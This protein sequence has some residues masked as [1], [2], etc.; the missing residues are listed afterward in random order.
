MDRQLTPSNAA[1]GI[2]GLDE[3]LAGGL[4]RGALFLVEGTPGTGKTTLALRFLIEGAAAGERTLYI[5]LS[6][7]RNELLQGAASH[8][9]TL[10]PNIEI[11]E[12]PPPESVVNADQHQSLLYS[13]DLELGETVKLIFDTVDRIQPERIVLDSLSEIR[14]LAQSSL[15]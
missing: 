12:L 9:W 7:T 6:E 10:D 2:P 8:G 3:I 4:M 1:T 11:F 5:T 13:S 14:L 15:R